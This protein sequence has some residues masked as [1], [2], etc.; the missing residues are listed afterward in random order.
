M[1]VVKVHGVV[2]VHAVAAYVAILIG[3]VCVDVRCLQFLVIPEYG[4]KSDVN[5][6][7]NSC[8][9][10]INDDFLFVSKHVN[11]FGCRSY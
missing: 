6:F 5:T 4:M 2:G 9:N 10:V 11:E 1:L 3:V 8:V 7:F